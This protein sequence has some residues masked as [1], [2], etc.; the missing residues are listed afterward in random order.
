MKFCSSRTH[1]CNCNPRI[2]KLESGSHHY[3][4]CFSMPRKLLT[5]CRTQD[6]APPAIE[7]AA[8]RHPG[9]WELDTEH[10]AGKPHGTMPLLL[11][12]RSHM[13]DLIWEYL[14]CIQ[15]SASKKLERYIIFSQES[16]L[17]QNLY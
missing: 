11:P 15:N 2:K 13:S 8:S 3:C 4:H 6:M 16:I 9:I 14:I 12:I 7:T 5:G 17:S 10:E 1:G